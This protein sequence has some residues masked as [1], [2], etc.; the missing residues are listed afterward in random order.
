M[1]FIFESKKHL[2]CM[3]GNLWCF[4]CHLQIKKICQEYS[5][6]KNLDSDQDQHKVS[7]AKLLFDLILYVPA[8]IFQLNRDGSSWVDPV[9]S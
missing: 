9:L 5:V 2:N 4:C 7:P 1:H 3:L 6:S 8:S